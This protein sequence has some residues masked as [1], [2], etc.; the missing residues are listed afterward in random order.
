MSSEPSETPT[1]F[2]PLKVGNMRLQ[3]RVVLAPLTRYRASDD[4]VASDLAVEYYAQRAIMPGTLLITEASFIAAQ[5]GGYH[6]V[7]GIWNDK[8]IA[9]YKKVRCCMVS[10]IRREAEG[11][12]QVA[13]AVH[14]KDSFIF[15]QLWAHGRA[16]IPEV[17]QRDSPYDVVGPSAIPMN[18]KHAIPRPLKVE[19]IKEYVQLYV[20]AAKNAIRAGFDG[21]FSS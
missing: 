19:E 21:A 14:E 9:A 20:Q 17:L 2:R 6:N 16:A 13:D 10:H 7:P 11:V 5:A 15:M 4:Y 1:L 8:Q 12:L 3:H 18:D